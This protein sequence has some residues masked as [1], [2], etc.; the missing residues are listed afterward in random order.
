MNIKV[1]GSGCKNCKKLYENVKESVK[2]LNIQAEIEYVT[3]MMEIANYGL[4]RTPG[5]VIN[6]KI[7]SYGKVNSV[8]EVTTIIKNLI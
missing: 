3:D 1:L 6:E 5:L 7:V 8:E 2:N 4:L